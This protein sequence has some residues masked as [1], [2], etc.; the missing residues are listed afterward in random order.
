MSS[1]ESVSCDDECAKD[2]TMGGKHVPEPLFENVVPARL[3]PTKLKSEVSFVSAVN[4]NSI[5]ERS[6]YQP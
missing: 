1:R 2:S 3:N 6:V 4:D 5:F